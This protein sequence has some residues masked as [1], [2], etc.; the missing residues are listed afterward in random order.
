MK[1]I[2]KIYDYQRQGKP[3]FSFE[4]FPPKTEAGLQNLY[5]RLDRMA[6]MEPC[7]IDITWGA[8]G[9]TNETTLTLSKNA[10]L[11]FGLD[12]MMHLTCANMS[13]EGLRA[14]LDHARD[15]GIRNILA[16]R[17]DAP[18][19]VPAGELP[20]SFIDNSVDLIKWIRK[21][22]GDTFSIAVGGYPEGHPDAPNKQ[23]CVE[24]LKQKIDAGADFILTQLFFDLNEYHGFL[25]R[26]KEVGITCPIIPGILPIIS[27]ER[28]QKFT[29]FTQIKVPDAIRRALEPIR[30][31][32]EKV[33]AYGVNLCVEMSQALIRMGAPGLHFY[34]LNLESSVTD[35]LND[36]K[37]KDDCRSR[38]S[39]PWR[40][41]KV[42][43]RK[44]EEVRP[45]F[46]GSSFSPTFG[47]L[48]DYYIFRRGKDPAIAESR[49]K[50]WGEPKNETEVSEVFTNFCL[51]KINWI[52]WCETP[53]QIE[54]G[55]IVKQLVRLN[56]TGFLTINSQPQVN[57]VASD[58]QEVG[59]GGPG[60]FVF[61]KAYVEFFCSRAKLDQL[62]ERAEQFPS[63]TYH[64]VNARGETFASHKDRTITAVTWGVFPGR[65]IIQPT[66]VDSESFMIWKDE[67]F[68]LWLNEWRSLYAPKSP[69]WNNLTS[70]HDEYFLVN[71]VENNFVTGDVYRIFPD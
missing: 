17:G 12:V 56:E 14:A 6:G 43:T 41:S 26:C 49:R 62:M 11:F 28:F 19:Y 3:F 70:I 30:N 66:V 18:A 69:A 46:W 45:I 22:Y 8:G 36:L 65:E 52:P 40:A 29:E 20:A 60:G 9:S 13:E 24:Y 48:N 50:I 16:L 10:Q 59:W 38:R 63:I 33:R 68:E 5:A 32:D 27:F 31:D 25:N 21:I 55:R 1:I 44:K 15:A 47:D 54:T 58:D 35:V 53:I 71:V 4:F 39:M 61:Q 51:G 57:G 64:A 37:L 34:T 67:A 2:D 23:Q 7:F 42:D